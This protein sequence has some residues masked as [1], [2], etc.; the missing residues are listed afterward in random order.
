MCNNGMAIGLTQHKGNET[1]TKWTWE[2]INK[3]KG[4]KTDAPKMM[5]QQAALLHRVNEIF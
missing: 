2:T 3:G 5:L 1:E 4:N